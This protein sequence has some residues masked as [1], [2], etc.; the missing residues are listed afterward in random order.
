MRGI[1]QRK[2]TAAPTYQSVKME[3][4][5]IGRI[6]LRIICTLMISQGTTADGQGLTTAGPSLGQS[7]HYVAESGGYSQS[8]R[9]KL[10]KM[11]E[12]HAE[13]PK[14]CRRGK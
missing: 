7:Q 6:L 9:T 12:E 11:R 14:E 3:I 10:I 5:R 4:E 8:I 1:V 13:M 2:Q